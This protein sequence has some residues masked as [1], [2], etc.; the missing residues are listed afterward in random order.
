MGTPSPRCASEHTTVR[1]DKLTS[2]QCTRDHGHRGM[3]IDVHGR[4]WT[5]TSEILRLDHEMAEQ[6]RLWAAQAAEAQRA[7][8]PVNS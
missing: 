7:A 1:N 6:A 3:C 2:T 4:Q 8:R 5:R